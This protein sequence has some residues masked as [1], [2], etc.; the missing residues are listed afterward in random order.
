MCV[1]FSETY[2]VINLGKTNIWKPLKNPVQ[3]SGFPNSERLLSVNAT[4]VNHWF[5]EM[6]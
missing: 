5:Q 6:M 3:A 2:D 1:A 4:V